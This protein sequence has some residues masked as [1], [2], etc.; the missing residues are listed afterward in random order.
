MSLW[1]TVA[2]PALSLGAELAFGGRSLCGSQIRMRTLRRSPG[3]AAGAIL[4]LALGIGANGGLQ[5]G[6]RAMVRLPFRDA[7]RL[8]DVGKRL[9]RRLPQNTRRLRTLWIG[10]ATT[11]LK[12]AASRTIHAITG[13][14]AP[15]QV[16]GNPVTANLFRCSAPVR[17]SGIFAEED[18]PGGPKVAQLALDCGNGVGLTGR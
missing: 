14:G 13:D 5:R 17:A 8:V 18:R 3:F 16:E 10:S 11:C 1:R 15:E 2:I 6:R 9:C 7:G 4:A 12:K